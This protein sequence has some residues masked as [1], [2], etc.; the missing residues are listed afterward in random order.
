M[1][2]DNNSMMLSAELIRMVYL[3]RH[4]CRWKRSGILGCMDFDSSAI[5]SL[6]DSLAEPVILIQACEA[7]FTAGFLADLFIVNW[8]RQIFWAKE[9]SGNVQGDLTDF[10]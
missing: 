8:I 7:I 6:V 5:S 4:I 2:P 1:T 9:F 10:V 3:S